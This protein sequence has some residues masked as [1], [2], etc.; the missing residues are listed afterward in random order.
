MPTLLRI[1]TVPISLK[2]LL[3]GQPRY[4][5]A[6]GWQVVLLSADGPERAEVMARE[7]VP[8]QLVPFTR[9]ITPW[10]DL[11]CLWQLVRFMRR[12]RPDI[13]HTHT[14]KAG[15]LG[16]LAARIAGVPVR[17]HTVA[18]LPLMTASGPRRRLLSL[19]ERL[20]YLGAQHVWP[21]SPSLLAYIRDHGLCPEAKLGMIGSGSSNGIDLHQY[22]P[23]AVSAARLS[24]A[25]AAIA[26]ENGAVYLLA[27]GRIVRDKGIA[28][29]VSA[30]TALHQSDSRLRLVL[31]GPIERERPEET[32]GPELL[33][34]LD[35]HPAVR[36]LPWSDDVPAFM[37]LADL[38]VHASHREG[39]PNVPLQAGAMGCPIV[40]SHIPGNIDIVDHGRTG[41]TYPVGDAQA[42]TAAIQAVLADPAAARKWALALRQRVEAEFDRKVIHHA[43]LQR[44]QSLLKTGPYPQ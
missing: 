43:L 35:A 24:A 39:F 36:H 28:E 40:C 33:Q 37:A 11:R 21:N 16:M 17:I 22:A 3:T 38:L 30:F 42:L 26:Y 20:T 27:V 23:D 19:M 2:L 9:A 15:L 7:G 13:V 31:L 29:L 10:Q 8:H 34:V 5:Q 44:Y 4:M 12:E 32:L 41:L 25:K 18:G 6:A 1:T 14:P